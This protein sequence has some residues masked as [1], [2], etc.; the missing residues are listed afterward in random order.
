MN[1]KQANLLSL[2]DIVE[3]YL[4]AEFDHEDAHGS[5]WYISPLRQEKTA[6]FHIT[7]VR[8]Y[9]TGERRW[10][11]KDFGDIGGDV[12]D[13]IMMHQKFAKVEDA[14]RLL[15]TW[16][17]DQK[18]Q[19]TTY[20]K[21]RT[22]YTKSD[23][24]LELLEKQAA[25]QQQGQQADKQDS[26][27]EQAV[28]PEPARKPAKAI[29]AHTTFNDVQIKDLENSTLKGYLYGRGIDFWVAKPYVK[30]MHYTRNDKP[31]FALVF[32]NDLGDWELRNPY[33]QGVYGRKAI[34]TLHRDRM[35]EG[36]T[37][38]VFEGFMDFLSALIWHGTKP[39]S[40]VIVLNSVEMKQEAVRAIKE[41]K[42]GSVEAYPDNDE[43]GRKLMAYLRENLPGV[44]IE[45]K[46]SLYADQ[47][48]NDFNDLLQAEKSKEKKRAVGR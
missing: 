40:A 9:Q 35:E 8:D 34:T 48:Y 39:H 46:S 42:A 29:E 13:L 45:D 44:Y 23:Q 33:Y 5:R 10:V 14:L 12:I 27:S 31:Y 37:V 2:R 4:H 47:G 25:P 22:S 18:K 41:L 36:G 6:S 3:T 11:W 43:A 38:I 19:Q 15:E 21:P 16:Y 7:E 30:E 28:V 32:P 20:R 26:A 17:G 24:Q 1:I